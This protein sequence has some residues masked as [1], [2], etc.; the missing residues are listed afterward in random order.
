MRQKG[1]AWRAWLRRDDV[2]QLR[3]GL[4]LDFWGWEPGR[5]RFVRAM[6]ARHLGRLAASNNACRHA[7]G[8]HA[9]S[10]QPR[11]S[12]RRVSA[13]QISAEAINEETFSQLLYTH[14]QPDVDL[15]IRTS[16]EQRISNF[17]LWQL[18]Y[19]ELYFTSKYWPE[20]TADELHAALKDFA[21][22]Q[23]RYGGINAPV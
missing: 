6:P 14:G 18:S 21:G 15:L 16:G 3:R 11:S 13:G 8:K 23:R 9:R 1:R 22:R 19:A 17:L 2:D 20:F 10:I 4:R 7:V 12:R 5:A